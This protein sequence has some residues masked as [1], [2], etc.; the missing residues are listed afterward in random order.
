MLLTQYLYR[1]VTSSSCGVSFTN[2]LPYVCCLFTDH[3]QCIFWFG[4]LLSTIPPRPD[5]NTSYNM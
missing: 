5:F 3:V 2:G 4:M 1:L